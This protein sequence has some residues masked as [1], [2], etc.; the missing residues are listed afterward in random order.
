MGLAR[1]WSVSL[2]GLN[3]LPVEV[4]VDVQATEDKQVLIIVGLP[5]TAVKEAKDR[6]LAAVR[7]SGYQLGGL[8]AT[9]NL[10]PGDLRKEGVLYDLP[11]ALGL[12]KGLKRLPEQISLNDYLIVGEL[13]LSGE[14]RPIQGALAIALLARDLGKK[15]LLLPASNARE[16]ASVPGLP[17]IPIVHLKDAIEFV[18]KPVFSNVK[19]VAG[20]YF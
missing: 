7:N 11:I 3:A 19:F 12:L 1:L 18:Q 10:A 20:R 2:M 13:G 17:V 4:E 14:M 15:A 16:A 6:V 8:Y 9:I 5:D